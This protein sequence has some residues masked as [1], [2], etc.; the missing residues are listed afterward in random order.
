MAARDL[1]EQD[2]QDRSRWRRGCEKCRTLDEER[3]LGVY[4]AKRYLTNYK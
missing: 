2:I 4:V 3:Y 1:D